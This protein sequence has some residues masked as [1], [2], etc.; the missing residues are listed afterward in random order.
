MKRSN[1]LRAWVLCSAAMVLLGCRRLP[2]VG[3]LP[4][5]DMGTVN[6]LSIP[7]SRLLDKYDAFLVRTSKTYAEVLYPVGDG[8]AIA[9]RYP[10]VTP[11][12]VTTARWQY[13]YSDRIPVS[14]GSVTQ[15]NMSA[16]LS[17]SEFTRYVE[18]RVLKGIEPDWVSLRR[19][20][21]RELQNDI[22]GVEE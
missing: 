21:V 2:S 4:G 22:D 12:T 17:P 11:E 10:L 16:A 19:I 15:V 13:V 6:L 1:M 20:L 9:K 5:S 3:V 14:L 18:K 7:R 8:A